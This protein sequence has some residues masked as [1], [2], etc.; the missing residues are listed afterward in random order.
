MAGNH[1]FKTT[2]ESKKGSALRFICAFL[3]FAIVFGSISAVVI[4]KNNEISLKDIFSGKETQVTE[5]TGDGETTVSFDKELTGTAD[6]LIYCTDTDVKEIYFM[7][8]VRADMDNR[9]FKVFPI[10]PDDKSYISALTTG[11]AKDLVSAVEKAESVKIDRYVSSNADTFALAINYMDGLEYEVDNRVEYRN[12]SYTLILTQGK[13][14]IKGETLLK[15][16]RY[17][18]TLGTEGYK[19]QGQLVCAMLDNYITQENIDEG[20]NIYQKVLSKINSAS[21]I[22]Y[23]EAAQAMPKLKLLC[24]SKDRKPATVI[25]NSESITPNAN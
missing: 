4:L 3:A 17:C 9:T 6:I 8:I 21:D 25:L 18:K 23:I 12:D 10:N 11:G 20:I 7:L 16:F 15:Y 19:T 5:I 22:S 1:K 13:Q 14:T 2:K 24:E